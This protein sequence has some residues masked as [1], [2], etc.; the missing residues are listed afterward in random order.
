MCIAHHEGPFLARASVR[1]AWELALV[2]SF[3]LARVIWAFKDCAQTINQQEME[4]YVD[5]KT[6]RG[7]VHSCFCVFFLS[8]RV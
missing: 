6:A 7:N 1:E 4:V 3:R 8:D 5:I 2:L